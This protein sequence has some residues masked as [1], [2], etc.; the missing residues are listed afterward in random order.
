[1]HAAFFECRL[2][3][4]L[5]SASPWPPIRSGAVLDGSDPPRFQW[6]QRGMCCELPALAFLLVCA[7]VVFPDDTVF[8]SRLVLMAIGKAYMA[9]VRRGALDGGVGTRGNRRGCLVC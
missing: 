3:N 7:P 8:N 4:K 2:L 1:M 9:E 5:A 6:K